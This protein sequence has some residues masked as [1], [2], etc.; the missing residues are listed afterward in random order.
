MRQSLRVSHGRSERLQVPSFLPSPGFGSFTQLCWRGRQQVTTSGW[1]HVE[2][3]AVR[4]NSTPQPRG[5]G[6]QDSLPSAPLWQAL[7][8]RNLSFTQRVKRGPGP[9][10]HTGTPDCVAIM[11][12]KTQALSE[13]R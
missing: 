3:E 6:P 9:A 12:A 13:L 2:R 5:S 1:P 10:I 4:R 11:L 8:S 7:S